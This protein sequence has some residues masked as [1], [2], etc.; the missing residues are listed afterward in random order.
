MSIGYKLED[1]GVVNR[2]KQENSFAV[3]RL[4]NIREKNQKRKRENQNK[5]QEG[6]HYYDRRR[7][8]HL[9]T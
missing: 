6:G 5:K 3:N 1:R 2:I 8:D 9:Q 7:S 4:R